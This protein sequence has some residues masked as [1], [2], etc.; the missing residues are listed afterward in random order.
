MEVT[1]QDEYSPALNNKD[2]AYFERLEIG[3]IPE[4]FQISKSEYNH[5]VLYEN[6]DGAWI[7]LLFAD[8]DS[9]IQL[10]TENADVSDSNIAGLPAVVIEKDGR[11]TMLLTDTENGFFYIVIASQGV[12]F[13]TATRIAENLIMW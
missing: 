7:Q 6:G 4:G 8:E 12:S 3:W 11:T 10:D 5:W 1:G 13:E 9:T 2:G